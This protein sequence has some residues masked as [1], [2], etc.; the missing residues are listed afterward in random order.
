MD[1]ELLRAGVLFQATQLQNSLPPT[2]HSSIVFAVWKSPRDI[3]SF[4]DIII[5]L[6]FWLKVPAF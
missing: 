4:R 3:S 1:V 2:V 5:V 6:I